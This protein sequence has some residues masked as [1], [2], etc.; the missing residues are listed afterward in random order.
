MVFVII[1]NYYANL[2]TLIYA[3]TTSTHFRVFYSVFEYETKKQ[4]FVPSVDDCHSL[5]T[6]GTIPSTRTKLTALRVIGYVVLFGG[7]RLKSV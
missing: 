5:F 3:T 6:Y 4:H 1:V 7:A 2:R